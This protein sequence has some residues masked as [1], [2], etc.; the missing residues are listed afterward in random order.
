MNTLIPHD[1]P[2]RIKD[3]ISDVLNLKG[4]G[5]PIN[6]LNSRWPLSLVPN[7][8]Q[9]IFIEIVAMIL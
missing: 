7:I 3:D 6:F 4:H 9:C 1:F 5:F 2:L 8:K